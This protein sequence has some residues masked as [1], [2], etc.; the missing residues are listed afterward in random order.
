MITRL[1][2]IFKIWT[3]GDFTWSEASKIA[4]GFDNVESRIMERRE[5]DR[6]KIMREINFPDRRELE[7]RQS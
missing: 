1:L 5:Q 2:G 3:F 4:D 7:R 6:R